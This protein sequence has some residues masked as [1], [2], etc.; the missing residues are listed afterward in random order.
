[1]AVFCEIPSLTVCHIFMLTLNQN[2]FCEYEELRD[3][4]GKSGI[5][6]LK[7]YLHKSQDKALAN[8]FRKRPSLFEVYIGKN[9]EIVLVSAKKENISPILAKLLKVNLDSTKRTSSDCILTNL[10]EPDEKDAAATAKKVILFKPGLPSPH[11]HISVLDELKMVMRQDSELYYDKELDAVALKSFIDLSPD[12]DDLA[13]T[14]LD[15]MLGTPKKT[16]TEGERYNFI[17]ATKKWTLRTFFEQ[18]GGL[19]T[20]AHFYP[21]LFQFQCNSFFHRVL[22]PNHKVLGL[23]ESKFHFPNPIG[24][25]K[26][27]LDFFR[28]KRSEKSIG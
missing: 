9:D 28:R 7:T 2:D 27:I 13:W 8:F 15:Y 20:I 11:N 12:V 22:T 1:M 5:G 14:L 16:M 26:K 10:K 6:D 24:L 17:V 4:I 21:D 25:L 23:D 19:K 3:L 18:I